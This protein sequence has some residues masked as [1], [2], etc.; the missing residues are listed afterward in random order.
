[1]Q[2]FTID[3]R[4]PEF[5]F[6]LT[7]YSGNAASADVLT[8]DTNTSVTPG[9]VMVTDIEEISRLRAAAREALGG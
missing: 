7:D 1:M 8:V 2:T 5:V 4:E 3:I 6:M 9:V